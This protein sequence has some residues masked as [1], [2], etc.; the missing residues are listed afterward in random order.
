VDFDAAMRNA[1]D[2]FAT[3]CAGVEFIEK[4][5]DPEDIVWSAGDEAEATTSTTTAPAVGAVSANE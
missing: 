5:P 3:M 2:V 1:S 4:V